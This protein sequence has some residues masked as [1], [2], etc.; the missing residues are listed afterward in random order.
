MRWMLCVPL[1]VSAAAVP[2]AADAGPDEP[3]DPSLL[4]DVDCRGCMAYTVVTEA[5]GPRRVC[6]SEAA[7][8]VYFD[9]AYRDA[10][11]REVL[12]PSACLPMILPQGPPEPYG[13]QG[14]GDGEQALHK[15]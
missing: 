15:S 5:Q 1:A 3:C 13:P 14:L 2:S 8:S 4:V 12:V 9:G 6:R 10:W 11:I 7:C